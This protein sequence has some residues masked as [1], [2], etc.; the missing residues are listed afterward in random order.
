VHDIA[1]DVGLAAALHGLA[2]QIKPRAIPFGPA[3]HAVVP[4]D[5]PA[6]GP[7][8]GADSEHLFTVALDG[9]HVVALRLREAADLPPG[10]DDGHLWAVGVS[11]VRL[12]ASRWLLRRCLRHARERIVGDGPLVQQQM[13]QGMI[14]EALTEQLEAEALLEGARAPG[15]AVL[16]EANVR[17]RSADRTLLRLLGASSFQAGLPS[18]TVWVSELLADAYIGPETIGGS[19]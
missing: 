17:I 13:V 8:C 14:A 2:E 19:E 9:D 3:G 6:T 16:T 4:A 1:R 10:H 5:V 7:R 11:W 18:H 15:M 12:G